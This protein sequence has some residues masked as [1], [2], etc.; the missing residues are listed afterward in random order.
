MTINLKDLPV[1]VGVVYEGERI[2]SGDMFIE[3]GGPKV[4][5]KA[6]LVRARKKEEIED[7]KVI[8]IGRDIQELEEGSRVPFGVLVEIYGKK[9]EKDLEPVIERR[10]HDFINYIHGMMHLNQRYDIWCRISKEAKNSN[11]TFE[12]VGKAIIYL[13]KAEFS[14]IEKIQVTLMTDEKEIKKFY[15]DAVAV[16]N[17]RDS[18]IRGMKDDEVEEFY[19]CTLCQ[20]FAPNHICVISPQRSSL[21]G[22]L[23]WLDCRAAYKIDPEG[24][25]FPIPKGGVMDAEKGEF[26]GVN[27]A[28]KESSHGD[29]ERI[30]M[31]SMFDFP[32]TSCGCFETIAFYM[33]EVD[34]VGIV[35]RNFKGEAINGL[36]FS[37][38]AGQTGGG[39]Q[40]VGFLGVGVN[41]MTSPKFLSADGGWERIVWIPSHIKERVKEFIPA[42][43]HD[44]IPTEKDVK[45]LDE[46]KGF[47]EEKKHPI[48]ER[49]VE[50][51][52]VEA[53]EE[54]L[55]PEVAAGEEMPIVSAPTMAL[56]GTGGIKII[57]KNAKIYADKVIIKKVEK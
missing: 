37:T 12:D 46:L 50:E 21:C 54:G 39:E 45:N 1:D 24:S 26:S 17:E 13:F 52:V 49:W 35:D 6:E 57:L 56:P 11:L 40:T 18:R 29:L 14:F 25:N 4:D 44:K 43:I 33:P 36:R 30:Y 16:Y 51:E 55:V 10:I 23:S 15:D 47:L 27:E 2:R 53:A 22:A 48:V 9:I 38:M 20:S 5:Y 41:W 42:E 34:G 7:E 28:I 8:V 31:Y 32:H 19:S 3:L